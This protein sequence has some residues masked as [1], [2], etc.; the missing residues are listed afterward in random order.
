MSFNMLA[1][2]LEAPMTVR[3]RNLSAP[4]HVMRFGPP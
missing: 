4:Q 2:E 3:L 1:M